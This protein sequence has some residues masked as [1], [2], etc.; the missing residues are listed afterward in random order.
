[1]ENN[2]ISVI[3]NHLKYISNRE[4]IIK[5]LYEDN[6]ININ[7]QNISPFELFLKS[8]FID[9]KKKDIELIKRGILELKKENKELLKNKE[10]YKE[11]VN[12]ELKWVKKES[13]ETFKKRDELL[14]E[15]QPKLNNSCIIISPSITNNPSSSD[16]SQVKKLRNLKTK[17]SQFE[18]DIFIKK[19]EYKENYNL[20][21]SLKEENSNLRQHYRQKKLIY[22]Q[23]QE[24]INLLKEK[25]E[26]QNYIKRKGTNNTES[27][28]TKK[29]NHNN[30]F[31]KNLFKK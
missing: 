20:N 8:I 4:N 2:G 12:E 21:L 5:M 22:R 27:F 23:L 25:I 30:S 15:I 26:G 10:I 18:T 11:K 1:M 6:K 24:D 13:K 16:R 29:L 28:T 31:F 9:Y 7:K 19:N 17:L 3:T 14:Q